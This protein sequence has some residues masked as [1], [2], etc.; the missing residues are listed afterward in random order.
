MR[1]KSYREL[2]AKSGSWT[3]F[4]NIFVTECACCATLRSSDPNLLQFVKE[5]TGTLCQRLRSVLVV[6]ETAIGLM[7][8][9]TAGLLLRTFHH[10]TP[11][12]SHA[13]KVDPMMA[14]RYE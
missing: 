4:F 14:L 5:G 11:R 8:L 6:A 7:L 9:V 10:L 2:I 12:R 13:M 3:L 1:C